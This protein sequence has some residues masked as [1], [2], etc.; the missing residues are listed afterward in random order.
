MHLGTALPGPVGGDTGVYVWN[1]WLFRHEILVHH[2]LPY[3]TNEILSLTPPVDLSLHNYTVFSDLL[4]FPL[5]QLWGS[6]V[7]YN[8]VLLTASVLAATFM[9]VLAARHCRSAAAAWLAGLLFAWS[10]AMVA[11]AEAH[12]SLVNV[13]AL[14]AF[15]LAFERWWRTRRVRDAF[16]AGVVVAWAVTSDPYYGIYCLVLA[17][18]LAAA[19]SIRITRRDAATAGYPQI[20]ARAL[21]VTIGGVV[22]LA[23]AIIATG[24][25]E[26]Q[27]FGVSVK[28]YTLY[29]PV[30]ALTLLGTWRLVLW[31]RPR[32]EFRST[33]PVHQVIV[34]ALAATLG[35]VMPLVPFFI[36][37]RARIED[38]GRFHAPTLWRSSPPG[39]DLLS[40]VAPNPNSA[41][42]RGWLRPWFE[43]Q[44]GGFAENVVS[45]T[46]VAIVVVAFAMWRYRFRPS[47]RWMVL[48]VLFAL[49]ALGP[50]VHIAGVN[51][52]IPGPWAFLRYVPLVGA[53][54]MPARFT[55]PLMMAVALVF[56]QSLAFIADRNRSR[57][58]VTY[59]LVGIALLVE[60]APVPRPLYDA[61]IPEIYRVIAADPRPIRVMELPLGFR[62]G[63]T[64]YG[65]FTAAS[66]FFQT[67][68]E[69]RLIGGYLSRISQRELARQFRFPVVRTI[70]RL[71]E[72]AAASARQRA[73]LIAGG[74]R[75]ADRARL[76]YVVIDTSRT[77]PDLRDLAIEALGLT[78]IG[79]DRG[80]ELY[81]V[82][83]GALALGPDDGDIF[84]APDMPINR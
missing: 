9:F 30:F 22:A 7:A 14:P 55:A 31:A 5:I 33:P 66:Q 3:F 24:G 34:G 2:R 17:A 38:G 37:L 84:P 16:L 68:H 4:S 81:R 76:G 64:S 59:A 80:Y 27:V 60:L 20:G 58:I 6:V 57:R 61:R 28:A 47:K 41:F 72:G 11:R 54:R 12:L 43:R 32:L 73:I 53:A 44:P 83:L 29:S 56:A 35:C 69:K 78:K 75:F 1:L 52:Y 13:A 15:V 40:I 67:F 23:I 63:E 71:S 18:A 8:L 79:E 46:T 74:R 36:A 82:P 21:N 62:D 65:N 26:T 25:F 70:T 45:I 77:S 50:F 49:T 51:T 48:A 19:A 39:V 10:P 42:V